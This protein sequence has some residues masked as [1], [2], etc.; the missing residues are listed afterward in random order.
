MQLGFSTMAMPN[1][2]PAIDNQTKKAAC[3]AF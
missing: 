2:L 3:A 1:N